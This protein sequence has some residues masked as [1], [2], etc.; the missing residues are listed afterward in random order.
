LSFQKPDGTNLTST[1]LTF[2]NGSYSYTFSPNLVGSWNVKASWGGDSEHE[3]ATSPS[4]SFTVSKIRSTISCQA[5]SANITIGDSIMIFGS[6]NPS[7]P[8]V[9]VAV[10]YMSNGLWNTLTIA[11]TN[12]NGSYSYQWQPISIGV[13]QLKASLEGD[14]SHSEA[15]STTVSVT[16]TKIST[17][18]SCS[19]SPQE[20]TE[21]NSITTSG[22]IVP[23]LSSE[24][25]TLTYKKPDGT[26]FARTVITSSSGTYSD[27]Y[28]SDA[29]GSWSV[30]ASWSGDST[31]EGSSSLYATFTVKEKP[32]IETPTGI[33]IILSGMVAAIVLAWIALKKRRT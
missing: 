28:K 10:S 26:T 21:G 18:I 4:V 15:M 3:G 32:F 24:T 19:S 6:I 27:S 9:N 7:R 22:S 8:A 29:K 16:V 11:K 13:Y 1:T 17:I 5:S 14:N 33:A 30:K 12:A 31:H 23:T 25:V 20:I 2:L